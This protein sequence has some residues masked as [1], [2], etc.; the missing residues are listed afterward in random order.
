MSFVVNLNVFAFLSRGIKKEGAE[1][2]TRMKKYGIRKREKKSSIKEGTKSWE[3]AK[4]S[5]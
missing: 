1:K 4:N 3:K 5:L 2:K